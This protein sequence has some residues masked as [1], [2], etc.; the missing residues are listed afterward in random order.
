MEFAKPPTNRSLKL[1]RV[2]RCSP[3]V[4]ANALS[5]GPLDGVGIANAGTRRFHTWLFF[6]P[7]RG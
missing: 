7:V 4:S 6:G 1:R 2:H 3:D 5:Q